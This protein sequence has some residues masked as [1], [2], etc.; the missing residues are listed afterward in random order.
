MG[1]NLAPLTLALTRRRHPLLSWLEG[2]HEPRNWR[3]WAAVYS[4][5]YFHHH[6][7][8]IDLRQG[9][10]PARWNTFPTPGGSH[11]PE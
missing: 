9:I 1:S 5:R 7:L 11:D 4:P 6:M 10:L 2:K 8:V 3:E